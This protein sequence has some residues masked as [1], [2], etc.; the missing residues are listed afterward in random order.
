MINR[1]VSE[2]LGLNEKQVAKVITLLEAGGSIP[3]IARY[4]KEMTGSLDEVVIS[5][6]HTEL[7]RIKDFIKRK[8]SILSSIEDQGLLTDVLKHEIE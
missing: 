2:R 8:E 3:F 7:N 6:I 4:R 5:K 1:R